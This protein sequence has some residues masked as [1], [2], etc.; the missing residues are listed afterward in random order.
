MLR[1]YDNKLVCNISNKF[2]YCR[3]IYSL[4]RLLNIYLFHLL[5]SNLRRTFDPSW[6]IY[7]FEVVYKWRETKVSLFFC[8]RS[9]GQ[10]LRWRLGRLIFAG[11]I[12]VAIT[13]LCPTIVF[14]N[15][16]SDIVSQTQTIFD[17][18][19]F[20]SVCSRLRRTFDPSCVICF[21]GV[22]YK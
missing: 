11:G 17:C 10:T 6:V 1:N 8:T 2:G 7:F 3:L 13:C 21:F 19:A 22:V 15:K 4:S 18:T 12:A 14:E 16:F 9:R 20:C 5:C